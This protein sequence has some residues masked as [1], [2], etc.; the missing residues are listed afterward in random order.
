MKRVF[1][2]DGQNVTAGAPLVAMTQGLASRR[3]A[4]ETTKSYCVLKIFP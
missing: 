3:Q 1:V 2:K 4:V